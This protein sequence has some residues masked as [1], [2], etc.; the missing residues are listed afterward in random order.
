M[1]KEVVKV[2][3]V[4]VSGTTPMLVMPSKKST[5]PVGVPVGEVTCA[6]KV[7]G[8]ERVA[9]LREE[10]RVVV[11]A[12]P[13]TWFSP[14]DPGLLAASAVKNTMM[15]CVPA[16][17]EDV[18]KVAI[19]W[20]FGVRVASV[21]PLSVRSSAAGTVLFGDVVVAVKVTG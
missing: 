14:A 15:L 2:T 9:G 19:P 16:V 13:T 20:E 3:V 5:T 6:V 17:S 21:A 11:V 18:V 1:R 8:W 10:V 7:M 4:P 12:V